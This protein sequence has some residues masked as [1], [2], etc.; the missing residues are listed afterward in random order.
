MLSLPDSLGRWGVRR[1][2]VISDK[3]DLKLRIPAAAA[4]GILPTFEGHM[5]TGQCRSQF[6]CATLPENCLPKEL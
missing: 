6:V 1:S 2:K 3:T 4:A 5:I